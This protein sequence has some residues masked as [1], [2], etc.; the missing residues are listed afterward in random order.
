MLSGTAMKSNLRLGLEQVFHTHIYT[1]T[2][3][4]NTVSEQLAREGFGE[5]NTSPFNWIFTSVSVGS[6]PR[7]CSVAELGEVP[8][9]PP[10]PPLIFRPNW[11]PGGPKQKFLEIAPLLI[12]GFGWPPPRPLL[13][14]SGSAAATD[15][16]IPKCLFKLHQSVAQNLSGMW[17]FLFQLCASQPRSVTKLAP[18][19][20]LLWVNK[21]PFQYGFCA[22][23]KANR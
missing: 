2:P 12:S 21:R 4:P 16:F 17:R 20:P 10:P 7:Y 14:R 5:L 23:A 3:T 13:W 22:G 18:K 1:Y 11:G 8:R 6:I 19:S 9:G 15:L